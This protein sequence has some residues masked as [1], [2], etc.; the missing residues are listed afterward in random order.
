MY[1]FKLTI[2]AQ[3]IPHE[4]KNGDDVIFQG[5]GCVES[6]VIKDLHDGSMQITSIVKPILVELKP[7][8][9]GITAPPVFKGEIKKKSMSQ[10]VR[11][12]L[13]VLWQKQG[14]KEDFETYYTQ[15]M[16]NYL[17]KVDRLI[18]DIDMEGL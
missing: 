4:L 10:K 9:I 7:S 18:A 13:Y 2:P 14:G 12:K 17:E 15:R 11:D 16:E 6:Q 1:R 5:S 3:E 8:T